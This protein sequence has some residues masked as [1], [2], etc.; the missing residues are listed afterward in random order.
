VNTAEF[1]EMIAYLKQAGYNPVSQKQLFKALFQNEKL[2]EKA[3]MITFDDGY[4]DNYS[5]AAPVLEKYGYPATFYIV[6]GSVGSA[7]YMSWEQIKD[8]DRRGMDIGSHSETHLDLTLLSAADL[9]SEL[10]GSAA[11]I[12]SQIG[13]PVYWLSFPGGSYDQDVLRFTAEA[14]YLLAVTTD[15]GEQQ[16]SDSPYGLMRYRVRSDTGV[17]GFKE[18]VR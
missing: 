17:E 13:H 6:T 18:Q 15:P 2:P 4:A 1:Q 8:L 7:E 11:A 16:S 14:G 3:V 5:V 12:T 10:S 9:R